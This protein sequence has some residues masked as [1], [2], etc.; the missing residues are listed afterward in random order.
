MKTIEA[1]LSFLFPPTLGRI[2]DRAECVRGNVEL[3]PESGIVTG[4]MYDVRLD[5]IERHRM[6]L[7]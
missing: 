3:V 6:G 2:K 7:R 4:R 1:I 5:A